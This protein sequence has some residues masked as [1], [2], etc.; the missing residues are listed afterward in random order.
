MEPAA[1]GPTQ[2]ESTAGTEIASGPITI[3]VMTYESALII[4][5]FQNAVVR[6]CVDVPAIIERLNLLAG[7]AREHQVPVIW[8][9]DDD[10]GH[11]KGSD[12]WRLDK[13]L[14][15]REDDIFSDKRYGDAFAET[16]LQRTLESLGATTLVITGAQSA[17]CI[18]CTWHSALLRGFNTV[19]VTD[20]HTTE[21]MNYGEYELSAKQIIDFTNL[22][23][24][25]GSEWPANRGTALPTDSIDFAKPLL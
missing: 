6:D 8:V 10:E 23:A 17:A 11:S 15:V 25:Y 16:S 5:D 18:R 9:Q 22:Y 12:A 4:I 14:D 1:R 21:D 2:A 7:K 20:A 24:Q 13:R 19:L 3:R